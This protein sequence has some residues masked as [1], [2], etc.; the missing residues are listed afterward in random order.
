MLKL[1]LPS[2][3]NNLFHNITS[4]LPLILLISLTKFV[5]IIFFL[6]SLLLFLIESSGA[7]HLAH[8]ILLYHSQFSFSPLSTYHISLYILLCSLCFFPWILLRQINQHSKNNSSIGKI[9]ILHLLQFFYF[10]HFDFSP[11]NNILKITG[12]G[13]FELPL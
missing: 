3:C 2:H 13:L 11:P 4:S 6:W 7:Q 12:N 1:L 10:F 8:I 5:I 9:F